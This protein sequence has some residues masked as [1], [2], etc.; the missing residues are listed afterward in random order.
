MI[1]NRKIIFWLTVSH[2]IGSFTFTWVCF[3]YH[4]DVID[5]GLGIL[6]FCVALTLFILIAAREIL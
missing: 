2:V 6:W 4:V 1:A 3:R 5:K